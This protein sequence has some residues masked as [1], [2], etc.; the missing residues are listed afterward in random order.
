[1][2]I[3]QL[4]Q[5]LIKTRETLSKYYGKVKGSV[6]DLLLII[7]LE[8]DIMGHCPL[9]GGSN[10]PQFIGYYYRQVI[11]EEGRHYKDFPIARYKC[12]STGKT[13]SLLPYQLAPY[14]RHCI[15][16]IIKILK[17]RHIEGLSIYELQNSIATL[18]QEDILT[19]AVNQI[20]RFKKIVI[21][22]VNKIRACGYYPEF[23]E[24]VK[25][26]TTDKDI[27]SSFIEFA[28]WFECLKSESVIKGPCGLNYD[29]YAFGGGY[30]HN[31]HFLFGTASQ[32]R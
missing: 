32:F 24:K 6:L 29:F 3:C 10:C 7:E 17:L 27:V 9:C 21:E 8:I 19:I 23:D 1:M 14:T 15:P 11:D 28:Q 5:I 25:D 12:T 20:N 16:L 31:A 26:K 2:I 22:A 30:Y 18:G 13:F 4:I